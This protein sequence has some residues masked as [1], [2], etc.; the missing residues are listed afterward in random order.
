MQKRAPQLLPTNRSPANLTISDELPPALIQNPV[1]PGRLRCFLRW[2][3]ITLALCLTASDLAFAQWMGK[4][5]ACYA[6]SIIANPNRPTVADPADI[7]QY[8]VLELEY[9]WDRVWPDET[10][11]THQTSTGGLL[12]FGLLC[13]LEW[14]W[15]TTSYIWQTYPGGT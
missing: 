13:D 1:R 15:T 4:Q 10:K 14:R 5:T 2:T 11:N 3:V 12:K 6:D 9:G 7:T 8:G